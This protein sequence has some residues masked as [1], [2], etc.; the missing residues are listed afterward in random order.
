METIRD[1]APVGRLTMES[2]ARATARRDVGVD[3]LRH[4]GRRDPR[5][6]RLVCS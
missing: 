6:V 5:A 3:E 2:A 4:S 1:P